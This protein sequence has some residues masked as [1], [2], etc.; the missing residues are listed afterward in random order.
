ME[1]SPL[2]RLAAGF[3][4][5]MLTLPITAHI[6]LA[7]LFA[8]TLTMTV[9]AQLMKA[10][11]ASLGL[12]AKFVQEQPFALAQRFPMLIL[13]PA[14][15]GTVIPLLPA[16]NAISLILANALQMFVMA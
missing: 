5:P 13:H 11:I 6:S 1:L 8:T 3:A 10:V 15:L 4:I 2:A 7:K 9:M 16:I 14:V 12:M